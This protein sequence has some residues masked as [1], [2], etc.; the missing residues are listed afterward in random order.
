M[1]LMMAILH[2]GNIQFTATHE[3]NARGMSDACMMEKTHSSVTAARLFG[4]KFEDLADALTYRAIKAGNEVVHSPLDKVQSEKACE[5]LMKATYGAAFDFIVTR[6]NESISNEQVPRDSRGASIGLLDI[7]GFETF[8]TNNFE[9]ICINYTNEALQQQFNKYVFKLEQDEYEREGILWKFISF[10]D[11]QDVLDLIDRKH[12]G[13]LAL[14]DEQCIV[15]RSTDEKFTRYL[16]AKCDKDTRFSATSAQRVDHKFSIEHYAGPVEYST[17]SWL[18]KN[19]DQLPA[20]SANLLKEADFDLLANIRQFIRSEGKEGRGSVATKSVGAQFSTQL[21]Q[22][23]SR[24]DATVPH[25]IR[26]LKPNDEL[27]PDSFDPRRIVD[28]LRCGGVLEAVRV[29]RAGYPTRYPHEVFKARYYILGDPNDKSLASPIKKW[30]RASLSEEDSIVKKLVSKIAFDIWEADHEAMMLALEEEGEL[31]SNSFLCITSPIPCPSRCLS[32]PQSTYLLQARSRIKSPGDAKYINGHMNLVSVSSVV[33]PPEQR[34]AKA[35]LKK[36]RESTSTTLYAKSTSEI[37]RPQT[38]A[39]FLSLDFS[40]R[41]AI[42]G[43]QLGKTKV[44][45][46]REAFDQIEHL[47]A[48]KFGKSAIKIQKI[49]RGNLARRYCRLLREQM[50]WAASVIQRAYRNHLV[51][52]FYAE[53][54]KQLVP[55]AVKIQAVARGANT[56]MWFFGT[57]YSIMRLQAVVRGYQARANVARLLEERHQPVS[58]PIQSVARHSLGQ[59]TFED[60]EEVATNAPA[61]MTQLVPV[62]ESSRVVVEISS[63]W[64]QLC[65]HVKEE[66]WAAV[67]QTLDQF[68]HLAE[69]VDPANGEMLLHMLCR[70]P[71]VWSLLVDMVVVLYPKALIHKDAIGAL[72]LH[73]AAA[74]DNSAA[75][76]IVFSAYKEGV[77]D[78]DAEG[79][80]PL[81]VAAEF[82]AVDGVKFLLEKAPEGAYTMVHR[83][84]G[85]SGGG[86]PLHIACRHHSNLSIITGLLAENFSSCKRSDENGDLP[87]HLLLRNGDAV[88]QVTV[89]TILTCFAGAVSRTDKNGDLPLTVAIKNECNQSVVNYLL[90]QYPDAAKVL[91]SNGHTNLHLALQ[92]GADDRTMLGLLN[93][94]P[95]VSYVFA[96]P[97]LYL[98]PLY[99]P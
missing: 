96:P 36:R 56:R 92:H 98:S 26:C 2:C 18:E 35:L 69:E 33:T 95:Q 28:Q 99:T 74:H 14:L 83:P 72:P 17:D 90:M 54:Q 40:S 63:E 7:F 12:T 34:R 20:S 75:L 48:L 94:A 82:D 60:E 79:R 55:A 85:E 87:L 4:V 57:L 21:A 51:N 38:A 9:Q 70:H 77:N 44:F 49:I 52:L 37:A 64:A 53:M 97:F 81:H 66:N 6:I 62:N 23:R 88:E 61:Q 47:R 32:H 73:H 30:G 22:L 76:E 46:R 43:L 13:I 65:K 25:Y 59:I 45:L 24:I 42:A 68:T 19:K 50:V 11:N 15:P 41:C 80:Q 31:V 93:H 84:K 67:E 8:E 39:E 58:S 3:A 91:D 86:L 71:N 89:K 29:S 78:V 1:R 5:A 10:P 16:Y 27:I